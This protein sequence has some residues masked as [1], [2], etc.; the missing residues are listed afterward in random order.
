MA[1]LTIEWRITEEVEHALSATKTN[2]LRFIILW[3]VIHR[4]QY[5]AAKRP[6]F[7]LYNTYMARMA[8]FYTPNSK[9]V[10]DPEFK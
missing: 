7:C 9:L 5:N 10:I 4:S 3:K 2:N 6:F 8:K 1:V